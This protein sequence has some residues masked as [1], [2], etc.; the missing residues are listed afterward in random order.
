M[1][2]LLKQQLRRPHRCSGGGRRDRLLLQEAAQAGCPSCQQG[3]G[4][5][6]VRLR[7]LEQ[8][9]Y[10]ATASTQTPLESELLGFAAQLS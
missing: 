10:P 1:Q 4:A 5:A 6:E 2:S 8:A 7:A 9:A 3:G